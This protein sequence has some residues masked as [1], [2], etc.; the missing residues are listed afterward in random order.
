MHE[1]AL[2]ENVV[3]AVVEATARRV[4]LV[5]LEIGVLAGVDLDALRFCFGVCTAGTTLAGAELDVVLV[6]ACARCRT[7]G[8]EQPTRSLAAART[9]GSFDRE[10]VTGDELRLKEVEVL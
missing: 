3:D 5:R 6:P 8:A 9:C 2:M 4:A 10:L 1:L 7:C